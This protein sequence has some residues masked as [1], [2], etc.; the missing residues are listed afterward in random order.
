MP[1]ITRFTTSLKPATRTNADHWVR[2]SLGD[3]IYSGVF[4]R[5]PELHVG[6]VEM[7]LA[8]AAQFVERMDFVY[9]QTARQRC[10]NQRK[11]YV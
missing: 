5:Y 11:W 4:E 10:P 7:E 2:Q 6:S 3:M 8:W 9:T 1:T